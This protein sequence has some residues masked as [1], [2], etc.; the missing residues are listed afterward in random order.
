MDNGTM[1]G[2]PVPAAQVTWARKGKMTTD[3]EWGWAMENGEGSLPA[4]L[5]A[6]D[7]GQ[8]PTE[9]RPM[10]PAPQW[11]GHS[12]LERCRVSFEGGSGP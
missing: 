7:A 9:D 12:I 1:D 4:P 3:G 8:T 5:R 6:R 11:N 10:R 2:D